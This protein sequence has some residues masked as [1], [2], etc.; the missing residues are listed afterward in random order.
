M[1]DEGSD[2]RLLEWGDDTF[3]YQKSD[4]KLTYD[5]PGFSKISA[6]NVGNSKQKQLAQANYFSVALVAQNYLYYGG[7]DGY[8]EE[9]NTPLTSI[10][11]T[12]GATK[13]ILEGR[14]PSALSR[15][16]FDSLT[17]IED[18]SNYYNINVKSGSAKQIDRR[19]DTLLNFGL[20]PNA[21]QVLWSEQ[22]DGQGN[23]FARSTGSDDTRIVAKVSGLKGPIRWVSDRLAVVRV[24]TTTE[25]AD[26]LFDIPTAKSAKIV[27][28][29]DVRFIGEN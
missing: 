6:Y 25:T 10:E 18:D 7:A 8:R 19:V 11:L 15:S 23:L 24:V 21:S 2:V 12:S 14:I 3:V 22:R 1:I 9:A 5:D 26:Y 13:Q 29:S 4:P 28:V 27:D 16:N 17:L 20:S